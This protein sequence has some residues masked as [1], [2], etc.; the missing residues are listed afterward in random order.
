MAKSGNDLE[1]ISLD[2]AR[3]CL[4]ESLGSD[5]LDGA[6]GRVRDIAKDIIR[7]NPQLKG[8]FADACASAWRATFIKNSESHLKELG[9]AVQV[10]L[11]GA[12]A[13]GLV[14]MLEGRISSENA[15]AARD[16]L[17]FIY[18]RGIPATLLF[19]TMAELD[20][21]AQ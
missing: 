21:A 15:K 16:V 14:D 4:A 19:G 11:S 1:K 2:L 9:K 7:R 6:D 18:S 12:A 3:C 10:A 20:A 8:Y 13:A 5:V 17:S